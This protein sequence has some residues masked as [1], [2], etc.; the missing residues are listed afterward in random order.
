M[1]L[2]RESLICGFVSVS[3]KEIA[4]QASIPGPNYS[5]RLC[6]LTLRTIPSPCPTTWPHSPHT[7]SQ[8]PGLLVA[9]SQHHW[10]RRTSTYLKPSSSS[11][12]NGVRRSLSQDKSRCG[13]VLLPPLPAPLPPGGAHRTLLNLPSFPS[14]LDFSPPL[15]CPSHTDKPHSF[16]G[17]SFRSRTIHFPPPPHPLSKPQSSFKTRLEY[18]LHTGDI[19][20]PHV[21]LSEDHSFL[22]ILLG[23]HLSSDISCPAHGCDS[24]LDRW[25]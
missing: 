23:L 17:H 20:V 16:P 4:T 15:L 24:T 22:W 7:Q 19:S 5:S 12:P 14:P 1:R 21:H 9:L 10:S 8:G 6:P 11:E 2:I 13:L 18:H 3:S 25:H